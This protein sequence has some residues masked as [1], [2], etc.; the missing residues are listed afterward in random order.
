MSATEIAVVTGAAVTVL[1]A[2]A[3][4]CWWLWRRVVIRWVHFLDDVTGEEARPGVPRRPGLVEEVATLRT[5][6]EEIGHVADT[7]AAD[8]AAVRH[9]LTRNGGNDT[10]KDMVQANGRSA[11]AAAA[12]AELAKRSALRTERLM[13]G[14]FRNGEE[15]M[16]VGVYNDAVVF[17]ILRSHGIEVTGLR[18]YPDVYM[19]D[20]V[21]GED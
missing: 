13:R 17:G 11:E 21:E 8:V 9:E 16:E 2:G 10:T 1:T 19:G 20:D 15:I 6:Q 7:A 3:A 5:R 4:F 12:S 14:H 18:E